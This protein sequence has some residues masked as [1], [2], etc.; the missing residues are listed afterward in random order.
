M[1]PVPA[2]QLVRYLPGMKIALSCAGEGFGHVSRMVSFAQG[3]QGRYKLVFFAPRTVH[4]HIRRNLPEVELITIPHFHLAKV[5]DRI[6]YPGTI[7]QNAA[8]AM[9]FRADVRRIR[10]QLIS[11]RVAAVI[12]DYEPYLPA[13]CRAAG[14]PVLQVNHPGVVV[15]YPSLSPDAVAARI[16]ARLMM[17]RADRSLYVSFFNGDIGPILRD[18]LFAS[19]ITRGDYYVVYVKPSYKRKVVSVLRQLGITNYQ[20]FPDAHRDFAAALAGCKG[21][22]TSAGH[23]TL[24]EAITLGKPVF[25]IPQRGQFEQRLNARMLVESGWGMKGRFS[26]LGS[27]LSRFIAAIDSFPLHSAAAEYSSP[28]GVRF[29]FCNDRDLAVALIDAFVQEYAGKPA[30]QR[31][32]MNLQYEVMRA[33]QRVTVQF[34]ESQSATGINLRSAIAS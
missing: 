31:L 17:G 29:R 24:S 27:S 28:G 2:P 9:S 21:V 25:A 3:L 15:R 26:N 11:L 1:K 8:K 12:N 23:Q 7:L 30:I 5:D 32:F 4:A 20:L 22:I 34:R 6:S 33:Y 18:Q 19:P 14:L 16:I 10:N 13:A